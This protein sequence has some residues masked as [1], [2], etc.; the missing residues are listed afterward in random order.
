MPFCNETL[1]FRVRARNIC[2]WS[3]WQ[4]L[5]YQMNR[6][7]NDCIT[8]QPTPLIGDNFILNPNPIT[9]GLLNITVKDGSPWFSVPVKGGLTDEN[10]LPYM[11]LMPNIRVNM[12]ILNKAGA[13]VQTINDC[14]MPTQLN[15]SNLAQGSY[16]V[17]LE[18]FG[19]IETYTIIKN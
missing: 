16:F 8:V 17:I 19:Q 11:T 2:G 14:L 5:Y 6:C 9:D 12:S 1:T 3:T 7:T 10:G 13:T 18:Y 4:E 15:L